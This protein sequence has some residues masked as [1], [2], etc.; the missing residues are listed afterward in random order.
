MLLT[1]PM[2]VA[3]WLDAT[4]RPVRLVY[5]GTRFTAIDEPKLPR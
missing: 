5:Q 2:P 3:V 1:Q 4:D